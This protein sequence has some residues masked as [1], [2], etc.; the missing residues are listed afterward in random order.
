MTRKSFPLLSFF[1]LF[2]CLVV[3]GKKLESSPLHH[4][5]ANG[6]EA[7]A[8]AL[9]ETSTPQVLNGKNADGD[10]PLHAAAWAGK[11][12]ILRKLVSSGA[13]LD[14]LDHKGRT[15]I[16]IA[17]EQDSVTSLDAMLPG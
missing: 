17:C 5:I 6:N 16:H 13:R 8:L 11:A 3:I 2:L 1:F 15:P 9:I 4:A 10:T 14:V 12:A 7:I